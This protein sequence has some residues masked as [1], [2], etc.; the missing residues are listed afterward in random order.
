MSTYTARS[1]KRKRARSL[2]LWQPSSMIRKS[3]NNQPTENLMKKD[4]CPDSVVIIVDPPSSESVTITQRA[5]ADAKKGKTTI[6]MDSDTGARLVISPETLR[7]K[8]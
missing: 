6:L 7:P 3:K 5:I 1:T 8:T 4:I 2:L